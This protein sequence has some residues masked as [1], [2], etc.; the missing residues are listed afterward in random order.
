MA[1]EPL[2]PRLFSREIH[3]TLLPSPFQLP[4]S[5]EKYNGKTKLELWLANF[6][7]ACQLGCA[8]WD[9]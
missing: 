7:L 8:R 5:I 9:D 3:S 1:L 4:T 2:G 6:W